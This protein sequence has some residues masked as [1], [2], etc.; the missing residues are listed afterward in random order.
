MRPRTGL[1]IAAVAVLL[2]GSTG[3]F[4]LPDPGQISSS[5]GSTPDGPR[6]GPTATPNPTVTPTATPNRTATPKRTATPQRT[7]TPSTARPSP[8]G[9]SVTT[10][11]GPVSERNL[12]TV[13]A[14]GDAGLTVSVYPQ[15]G[16]TMPNA[17]VTSCTAERT[18]GAQTLGDLT[19]RDPQ[20]LGTWDEPATTN[21][22]SEVIAVAQSPQLA[23]AYARRLVAAQTVCQDRSRTDFAYGDVHTEDLSAEV[24]A[25]WLSA[26]DGKQ[27]TTEQAPK[28]AKPCGGVAVVRNGSHFAVFECFICA[29]S[30]QLAILA[31]AAARQ[32]G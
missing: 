13:G 31:R 14:F 27:N 19:G 18:V 21:T 5:P 28:G 16:N 25:S 32:L 23:D 3:A 26:Y 15:N 24:S 17:A 7:G 10:G 9:P 12:L 22:A 4:L 11:S 6:P 30:D 1:L 8:S 29:D 2:G 20:V